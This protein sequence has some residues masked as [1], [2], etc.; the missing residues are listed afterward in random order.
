MFDLMPWRKR[1]GKDLVGFKSEL[2]N[3]FNRF[4]DLDFPIS[5][6][7]FK[8]GQWVPRVDVT[9]GKKE[10]YHR[11]PAYAGA[12]LGG[13]FRMRGFPL[14]RFNDKA[15]I[16]YCGEYRMTPK[17]NPLADISWVQ[18][19]LE[20][21]WWQWVPFVEV[22][23]VAGADLGGLSLGA[24]VTALVISRVNRRV[25]TTIAIGIAI[26]ANALCTV[27]FDYEQVLWLR[28]A[29]GFGSGVY[30]AVAVA[31]LGATSKPARAYNLMLF[32]FVFSQALEMWALPK[33]TMNGIFALS[34][35]PSISDTIMSGMKVPSA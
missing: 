29:A 13:L 16:Y 30:T 12:T 23:R 7:F 33:L 26:V 31:N 8:E 19:F 3:L 35:R 9:E 32:G 20:I 25:L 18:K 28:L 4:F 22:G 15:A 34:I 27:I 21:A 24:V 11:P 1:E 10:I 2:D 6:E 14:N 17:W 5:R